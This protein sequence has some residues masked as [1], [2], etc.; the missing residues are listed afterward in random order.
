M[1]CAAKVPHPSLSHPGEGVTPRGEGELHCR[2]RKSTVSDCGDCGRGYSGSRRCQLLAPRPHFDLFQLRF[3]G[4][5]QDPK[6]R[7][8]ASAARSTVVSSPILPTSI[9]P[10]GSPCEL[11]HG[12]LIAGCP[13]IS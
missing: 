9:I 13:L 8:Q 3:S 4:S 2:V 6:L 1:R 7:C 12:T 5:F 11:P 10:I